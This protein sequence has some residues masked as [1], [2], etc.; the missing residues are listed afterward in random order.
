MN[1]IPQDNPSKRFLILD[2]SIPL[3]L[4]GFLILSGLPHLSN[5]YYFLGSVYRYELTSP[6]IA[7]FVAMTLPFLQLILAVCLIFRLFYLAAHTLTLLMLFMFT[8]IQLSVIFRGLDISCGCFGPRYSSNISISTII[9]V[10]GLLLLS[11]TWMFS[12]WK[13]TRREKFE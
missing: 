5:P 11:T 8:I 10:G 7:Q 1:K 6:G 3:V 9:T 2:G 13:T 4:G 12:H